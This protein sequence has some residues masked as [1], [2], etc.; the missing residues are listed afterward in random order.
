VN[1]PVNPVSTLSRALALL[2]VLREQALPLRLGELSA[3]TGLAKSTVHRLLRE[4]VATGLV[5][6][7]AGH[8][9]LA[10]REKG[11]V[12]HPAGALELR[13][14][15]APQ[16]GALYARTRQT[17]GLAVLCGTQAV[18]LQRIHGDH[19]IWTAADETGRAAAHSTAAGKLLMAYDRAAAARIIAHGALTAVT[20][21]TMVTDRALEA[22][23][24][25]IVARRF[26]VNSGESA[27][28]AACLAVPVFTAEGGGPRAAL[29]ICGARGRFD[30]AHALRELAA[31]AAAAHAELSRPAAPV[32]AQLRARSRRAG[33]GLAAAV[34]AV[35]AA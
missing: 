1:R 23:F 29:T 26:A 10:A 16:L 14:S 9:A 25:R 5:E 2:D 21:R 3:A 4:L 13:R 6:R 19:G 20:P 17:V 32:S 28:D 15:L 18:F 22:E 7:S 34:Q 11:A 12:A 24:D 8:Y 35:D 30:T 33:A 31:T 27:P